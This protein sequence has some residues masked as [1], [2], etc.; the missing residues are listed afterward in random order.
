[1]YSN[2]SRIVQYIMLIL[3]FVAAYIYSITLNSHMTDNRNYNSIY[4]YITGV[5]ETCFVSCDTDICKKATSLRGKN[6]YFEN[7]IQTNFTCI[8]TYWSMAHFLLFFLVGFL[9]PDLLIEI[10]L[11]GI[12][13]ELYEYYR[14]DCH[15]ALDILY[16]LSGMLLGYYT[17]R[18][19]Y[20]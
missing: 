3:I 18:Y 11:I 16:D 5:H 10:A 9:F 2:K 15:D 8:M 14:F 20:L 19:I 7:G 13:F 4:D 1:M 17:Y 12:L 6:Y